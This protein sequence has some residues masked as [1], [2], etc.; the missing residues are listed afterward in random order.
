MFDKRIILT[1]SI[2]MAFVFTACEKDP[3]P[4]PEEAELITTVNYL[5]VS[6]GGDEI[7]LSFN[8]LDGDG[9]TPPVIV[10]GNLSVN[11]TYTGT[12]Q[13]LNQS[14]SPAESI[15]EEI[16][17]EDEEHQFFFE[18]DIPGLRIEY[19]DQDENGNPVGLRNTITTGEAGSGSITITLRHEPDKDGAGV[20]DGD[21]A[22][23]GGETDIEV[24]FSVDV[25]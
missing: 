13:L 4:P 7:V 12:L 11:E 18:S 24:T 10:N 15:T 3:P 14:V 16:Q 1:A 9:G 19:N 22:N 20:S 21:I 8:D 23:A 5:L 2:L 17:E 6:T 25:L